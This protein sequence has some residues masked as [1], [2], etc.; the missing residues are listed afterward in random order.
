MRK[1]IAILIAVC[2]VFSLMT[3]CAKKDTQSALVEGLNGTIEVDFSHGIDEEGYFD[4]IRA[5]DYVTLPEGYLDYEISRADVETSE[6]SMEEFLEYLTENSS[7]EFQETDEPAE[8]GDT[9]VI[10]YIGRFENQR[11]DDG[12]EMDYEL[13]LGSN[14]F[15]EEFEEN[16]VGAKKDDVLQ[17]YVTFPADVDKITKLEGGESI[18]LAGKIVG[19]DVTVKKVSSKVLTDDDVKEFF[20][21]EDKMLDGS[22]VE[23]VEDAMEYFREHNKLS[24]LESIYTNYLLENSVIN[25]PDE[26]LDTQMSI[27]EAYIM[28]TYESAG[29]ETADAF[30]QALGYENMDDYMEKGKDTVVYNVQ[31]LLLIQAISE[32]NGWLSDEESLLRYFGTGE[33]TAEDY[34]GKNYVVQCALGNRVMMEICNILKIVD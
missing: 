25:I 14:T 6:E 24:Q 3:G 10:D 30:V 26:V 33:A 15:F 2:C 23:T 34:Y 27:E 11:F 18:N 28:A 1:F 32:D 8:I 22:L 13:V 21:E 31:R 16:L 29:Y 4:G 17:F 9:V 5:L 20:G 12:A 7:A 19:F